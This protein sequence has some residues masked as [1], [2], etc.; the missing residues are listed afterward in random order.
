MPRTDRQAHVGRTTSRPHGAIPFRGCGTR[1]PARRLPGPHVRFLGRRS[2]RTSAPETTIASTVWHL[3]AVLVTV[4]DVPARRVARTRKLA[5]SDQL[6]HYYV[7]L[8]LAAAGLQ[9]EANKD[10]VRATQGQPVMMDLGQP[11]DTY[12][13]AGRSM[14]AFMPRQMLDDLLPRA[15]GLHA[16]L[17]N[18]AAA[19]FL[20]DLL[21]SLVRRLPEMGVDEAA[22]VAKGTLQMVAA[23]VA[24]TLETREAARPVAE[25]SLLRQARHFIETRLGEPGFG[26]ES[27]C[28]PLRISR[29]SLYRLF[30]PHGGVAAYIRER[31]LSRIHGA[32]AQQTS[33]RPLSLLA[34]DY[35]FKS[36]SQFRGII[37]LTHVEG[38]LHGVALRYRSH[39][40][41]AKKERE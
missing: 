37:R 29:A 18:G 22:G 17:M 32:I 40:T 16:A 25:H 8:P 2:D 35:G 26:P 9:V 30:E 1:S 12:Q 14:Q 3:G 10:C 24:P 15:H 41:F 27:L 19:A 28:V 4:N 13:G 23:A 11:F 5:R 6:D 34:E 31:R 7:H 21:L 39:R 20:S 36:A 38:G 33:R